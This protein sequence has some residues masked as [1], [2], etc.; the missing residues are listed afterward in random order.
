LVDGQVGIGVYFLERRASRTAAAVSRVA[1]I[2]E[3]RSERGSEGATWRTPPNVLP[4]YQ[5]KQ[6]RDGYYN[7]GV[8]HGVPGILYFLAQAAALG[9]ETPNVS[10]LAV[11]GVRWLLAQEQPS[12]NSSFTYWVLGGEP[13]RDSR[14]AWCYGDL[15]IGMLLLEIAR[16][17]QREDW[18]NYAMCLLRR[19]AVRPPDGIVDAALCHGALGVALIFNRL[20]HRTAD[21]DFRDAALHYYLMGIDLAERALKSGISN[22][23]L[24]E[25]TVGIALALLSGLTVVEPRWDRK[26]LLSGF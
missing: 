18:T 6:A 21:A 12:M 4:E 16:L 2:L 14:I 11:E 20:Y 10:S 15:G 22:R 1:A 13:T 3:H 24:L 5:R 7:L 8:A 19:C 23:N 9:I 25:G 26:L 17:L